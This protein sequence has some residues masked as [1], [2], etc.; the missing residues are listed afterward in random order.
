[1]ENKEKTSDV[2]IACS[3]DSLELVK[4][5]EELQKDI[6]RQAEE[7]IELEDAIRFTF[8]SSPGFSSRLIEFINLERDCCPFF[9]FKL[10]F[11][12]DHGPITLEMG[13]SKEAKGMLKFLM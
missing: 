2:A 11:K 12:P 9:S 5:K 1:M 13:G 8:T 4:R 6:F 10:D 7:I 3:L